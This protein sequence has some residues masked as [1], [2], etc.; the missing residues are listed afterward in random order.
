MSNVGYDLDTSGGLMP[1]C[2]LKLFS[3]KFECYLI[4]VTGAILS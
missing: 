1:V 2:C 3:K 4:L